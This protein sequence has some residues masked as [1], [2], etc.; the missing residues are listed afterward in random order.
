MDVSV[1]ETSAVLFHVEKIPPEAGD[2]HY[3]N[4]NDLL[5]R[6]DGFDFEN[7]GVFGCVADGVGIL[8]YSVRL[9]SVFSFV[10]RLI[11]VKILFFVRITL[12]WVTGG[13]AFFGAAKRKIFVIISV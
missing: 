13:V 7:S 11:K 1:S 2:L 8:S 5:S 12:F 3:F 10:V 4:L 6:A 9:F